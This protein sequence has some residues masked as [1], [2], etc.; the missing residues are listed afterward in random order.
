MTNTDVLD[1]EMV[2][3]DNEDV[4]GDETAPEDDFVEADASADLTEDEEPVQEYASDEE[5]RLYA[6]A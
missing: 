3:A 4:K 2:E 6:S 1:Q 5:V